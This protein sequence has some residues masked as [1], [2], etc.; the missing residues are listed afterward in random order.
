MK[1]SARVG[2]ITAMIVAITVGLTLIEQDS[3]PYFFML[4]F[5]R[6]VPVA[7]T[8]GG[9]AFCVSE[10]VGRRKKKEDVE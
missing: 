3:S 7:F 6:A 1:R 8:T 5:T 2:M 4:Y 10:I 9:L